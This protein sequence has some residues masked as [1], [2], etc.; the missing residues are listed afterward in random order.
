MPPDYSLIHNSTPIIMGIVNVTPDS[1]SDGGKYS[2]TDRAV[3]HAKQLIAEGARIIDIGGESTRPNAAE[4]NVKDEEKRVIPVI[5]AIADE[6]HAKGVL[7]S[8]DTRR[9]AVMR[10][11]LKAGADIIN[12]VSALEDDAGSLGVVAAANCLVCLMHKQGTP[13]TMQQAPHYDDVVAEVYS[14]L[15]GR[16]AACT[17]AGIGLERIMIDVGIGFGKN[18]A[19][20]LAL[21]DALD[22]FAALGVPV[23][24][25]AS[26]KRFIEQTCQFDIPADQRLGGSLAAVLAG[27]NRGVR[28]FRVH[29]VAQTVQALAVYR[30]IQSAS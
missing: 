25:G 14:Y 8:V 19:H 9:A 17:Q 10:A 30:A 15:K 28:I 22:Q 5:Q 18:L 1:F 23:L 11:A 21:L 27:Y 7:I 6:A 3:S 16:V 12:D 29:D 13:Q 2:D 20:N 4:V 24:L 26:R